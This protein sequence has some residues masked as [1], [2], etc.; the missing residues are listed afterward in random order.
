MFPTFFLF[1]TILLFIF[2]NS[3][4]AGVLPGCGND[5]P[6]EYDC[7]KKGCDL[8]KCPNDKMCGYF[9]GIAKLGKGPFEKN[10]YPKCV[11]DPS[12]LNVT[13]P[14]DGNAHIE[15]DGPG[16]K[17][18]GCA[19]G[20]Q[21]QVRITIDKHGNRPYAQIIGG[22]PQCVNATGGSFQEPN[23]VIVGGPGC[24]QLPS[25]CPAGTKC[26]TIVGIAKYGKYPWAQFFE[27]VCTK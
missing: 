1:T 6:N 20:F 14:N 2:L 7:L 13:T 11:S 5:E 3:V 21:C 4:H 22:F 24:D 17:S 19:E 10:E 23:S 18:V 26:V 25:P 8:I 9:V 16:C 15:V 27:P 12:E